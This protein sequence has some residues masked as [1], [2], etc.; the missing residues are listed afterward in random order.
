MRTKAMR[1]LVCK[2]TTAATKRS[3]KEGLGGGATKAIEKSNELDG[4]EGVTI[5]AGNGDFSSGGVKS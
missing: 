5:I 3:R 2:G 1:A 4:E